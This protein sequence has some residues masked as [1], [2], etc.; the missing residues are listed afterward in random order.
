LDHIHEYFARREAEMKALGVVPDIDA[1]FA[2]LHEHQGRMFTRVG[3]SERSFLS[4][5]EL[6]V[7][8]GGGVKH[9]VTYSYYLITDEAEVWG[10]DRDPTH[11]PAEHR[12]GPGHHRFEC[13]SV[14]FRW[15]VEEAW[16]TYHDAESLA[17][18]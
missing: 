12:H 15:A 9:R 5:N 7:I 10:Y 3:L 4:I 1:P 2:A 11:S 8:H 18:E 14:S 17:D 16:R 6:V 13:D